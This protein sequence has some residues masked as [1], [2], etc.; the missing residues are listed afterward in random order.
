MNC[1]KIQDLILTDYL[2]DQ[3]SEKEKRPIEEHLSHCRFCRDF[4]AA[5]R[6]VGAGLF[7]NLDKVGP[8]EF[9]WRRIRENI[10]AQQRKKETFAAKFFEKI[11]YMPDISGLDWE[12]E[13]TS[14][15]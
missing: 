6:K 9:V 2:D 14:T 3:I 4:A 11:K 1:K 7:T 8:P 5:A 12:A 15:I 13:A 10:I